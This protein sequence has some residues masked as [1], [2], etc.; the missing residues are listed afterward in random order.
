MINCY[1]SFADPRQTSKYLY[2]IEGK[3][4]KAQDI[5]ESDLR[6]LTQAMQGIENCRIQIEEN[7]GVLN[8]LKDFY[9][10][11]LM[12]QLIGVDY[13]WKMD[14]AAGHI[15]RFVEDLCGTI[16]DTEKI[17]KRANVLENL[18]RNRESFVSP[19]NPRRKAL[20]LVLT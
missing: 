17:L 18:A 15:E 12:P 4:D 6:V 3:K 8:S 20:T 14:E 13:P 7:L 11:E 2:P 16:S 10:V 1:S 19:G 5:D 9:G